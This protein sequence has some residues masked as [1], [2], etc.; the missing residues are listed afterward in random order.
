MNIFAVPHF[1]ATPPIG[2]LVMYT[3]TDATYQ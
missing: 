3:T 2:R 1:A